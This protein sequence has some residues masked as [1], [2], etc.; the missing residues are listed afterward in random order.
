[1]TH[2][3]IFSHPGGGLGVL[4]FITVLACIFIINDSRGSK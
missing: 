2:L 3:H 4:I 1:M